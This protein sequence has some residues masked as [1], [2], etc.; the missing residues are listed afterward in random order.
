MLPTILTIYTTGDALFLQNVLN[1]VAMVTGTGSFV[2]ASAIGMLVGI[3]LMGFKSIQTGKGFELSSIVICIIAWNF[4]FGTTVNV[5]VHD[6]IT[7]E[8]RPVDNVPAGVGVAGWA[9][10]NIAYGLTEIMEQAFQSP[11]ST[12]TIT[13]AAAGNG[14]LFNDVTKTLNTISKIGMYPQIIQA[15]NKD[16]GT[17]ADF[18]ASAINFVKDCT[19]TAYA[20]GYKTSSDIQNN[21][22]SVRN[23]GSG[24]SGA[25]DFPEAN[26]VYFTHIKLGNSPDGVT[27][28]CEQAWDRLDNAL[29]VSFDNSESYFNKNL[30]SLLFPSEKFNENGTSNYTRGIDKAT[31]IMSYATRGTYGVQEFMK[32]AIMYDLFSNGAIAVARDS[33]DVATAMMLAQA[34]RQRNVQ[35]SSEGTMFQKTMRPIMTFMEGFT[36]AITPFCGFLILMGM[37]GLKLSL[38]YFMLVAWVQSWLPCI[39]IANSY[40]NTTMQRAI[41]NFAGAGNYKG[42][43]F[44]SLHGV[45]ILADTTEDYI[46]TGG[47]FMGAIPVITLFIFS[48]SVYALNTLATRMNGQDFINEKIAAPDIIS[49]AAVM[50]GM[51]QMNSQFGIGAQVRSNWEALSFQYSD[52]SSV[53]ASQNRM[54]QYMH[55]LGTS[56]TLSDTNIYS[57]ANDKGISDAWAQGFS[58]QYENA[59]DKAKSIGE[60]YIAA[61]N[62][63]HDESERFSV[64]GNTAIGLGG[65]ILAL[66]MG[67]GLSDNY[68]KGIKTEDASRINKM[69][70]DAEGYKASEAASALFTQNES[71]R[72]AYSKSGAVSNSFKVDY[73]NL[74]SEQNSYQTSYNSALQSSFTKSTTIP[75][76][77]RDLKQYGGTQRIMDLYNKQIQSNPYLREQ[78]ESTYRTL[79]QRGV[80][81]GASGEE[82]MA[83]AAMKTLAEV[84]GEQGNFNRFAIASIL[85][86]RDVQT[87][88][89]SLSNRGSSVNIANATEAAISAGKNNVSAQIGSL[90]KSAPVNLTNSGIT[91]NHQNNESRVNG[92]VREFENRL[93]A[94][95]IAERDK[96]VTDNRNNI[97]DSLYQIAK[98]QGE[99]STDAKLWDD[100]C[101]NYVYKAMGGNETFSNYLNGDGI[102]LSDYSRSAEAAL[103]STITS[104]GAGS[105]NQEA[106]N[107]FGELAKAHA[108]HG[109]MKVK[110]DDNFKDAPEFL[111]LKGAGMKNYQEV[112]SRTAADEANAKDNFINIT[113]M[114]ENDYNALMLNFDYLISNTGSSDAENGINVVNN[115]RNTIDLS[116]AT[117]RLMNKK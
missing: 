46:A 65:N 56:G 8:D 95:R 60:A 68:S 80:F 49:P 33:N 19:F 63:Y 92:K 17:K 113:G 37:F 57:L 7:E 47:M 53:I 43:N 106:M 27:I 88:N 79:D 103:K 5:N 20:L 18:R 101:D 67:K 2:T 81:A 25:L 98:D 62:S 85:E 15:I 96:E 26:G 10:S 75:Q 100:F 13:G 48:G 50:Q 84:G 72:N 77:L 23:T 109:M 59:K 16:N 44:D 115:I 114:S 110:T 102:P 104:I 54:M 86:G 116:C 51:S 111:R 107:A 42:Y 83:I 1:A 82:A 66:S 52:M 36:Y 21:S 6:V 117:N 24:E 40:L 70:N 38:K 73:S 9:I 71:I 41:L 14:G 29:D 22:V 112:L 12:T 89:F 31:D 105:V 93:E 91:Q 76:A 78:A 64:G 87:P 94:S 3:V 4:F 28:G 97:T 61:W 45:K 32:A 35:W 34:R 39:A 55:N 30:T 90:Q 99:K 11:Y 74:Q 69:I 108:V 58:G